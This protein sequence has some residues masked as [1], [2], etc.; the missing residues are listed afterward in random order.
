MAATVPSD[1]IL[2]W[3]GTEAALTALANWSRL[4]NYDDRFAQ[5]STIS[6]FSE[7]DG[8]DTSHDHTVSGTH[9][10]IGNAH[11][12]TFFAGDT[13]A[14]TWSLSTA[15]ADITVGEGAH[16]HVNATSASDTLTY[17]STAIT[18]DS[19]SDQ[20]PKFAVLIF[21]GPSDG[22]QD[23]PDNTVCWTDS[24]SLPTGFSKANGTGTTAP[25]LNGR[26]AKSAAA[27]VNG[28]ATGGSDTHTHTSPGHVH[29]KSDS[30][31][32]TVRCGGLTI[33]TVKNDVEALS[34][35]SALAVLLGDHHDVSLDGA[36]IGGLTS[37]A[38]SVEG[39]T[40]SSEPAY[41]KLMAIENT[42]GGAT[43]P[44][45]VIIGFKGAVVPSNWALCDGTAGTPTCT[46]L[47]IKCTTVDGEIADT[48]GSDSHSHN[49]TDHTHTHISSHTHPAA[50]NDTN[51]DFA[52]SGV[53]VQ[54]LKSTLSHFLNH[55]WGVSSTTP[56]LQ[57]ATGI[58]TSSDD[59]RQPYRTMLFIKK[60]PIVTSKNFMAGTLWGPSNALA[61]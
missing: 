20:D 39:G 23:I 22:L 38:V 12:H 14:T 1:G 47:Q 41:V 11:T 46:N 5:G 18:I 58:V 60:V 4:S 55:T 40:E 61:G 29:T 13:T 48:G 7:T 36:G 44:D 43:T 28:G 27:G 33:D 50:G 8:N 35:R 52:K 51:E 32:S 15:S 19:V 21:M 24:A 10:H 42:S 56:T 6:G 26:F 16:G 3:P 25:D 9:T 59:G 53:D 49:I 57:N 17:G 31:H 37:T 54:G 45:G 30:S 2:F 34:G